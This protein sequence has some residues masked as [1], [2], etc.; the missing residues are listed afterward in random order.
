M[1]SAADLNPDGRFFA[2]FVSHSGEGKTTAACSFQED[3]ETYKKIHA[4]SNTPVVQVLDFD[5]RIR[6]LLGAPWVN[7]QRIIYS[8]YPPRAD[9][10]DP[11]YVRVNNDLE[12]LA[13]NCKTG[14]NTIETLVLDSLTSETFAFL[15]DAMPMTHASAS[16]RSPNKGKFIGK[17][18]MA[19]PEDYGFESQATSAVLSFLRSLPIKNVIVTA[20]LIDRYGKADPDD[21]YS[22]SVVVGEKLS[23]RDKIAENTL[24]YFDHVFKFS[25]SDD[26]Q[27]HYVEFKSHMARSSFSNLPEGRT[28][29]TGK[30]FY[31]FLMERTKKV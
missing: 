15:C 24:I 22:A 5:G 30:N 19:G 11:T 4:A 16:G 20:H 21:P 25:K 6:G 1:P 12:V 14:K 28:D 26:G 31:K 18:P 9:V 3:E 13:M 2:L 17:L 10:G 23:L 7:R 8:S 29:I 27:R